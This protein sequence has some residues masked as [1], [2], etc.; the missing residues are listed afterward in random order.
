MDYIQVIEKYITNSIK[1]MFH[2]KQMIDH[3][4]IYVLV[5]KVRAKK[6]RLCL[7]LQKSYRLLG[8]L[9]FSTG[10]L[11]SQCYRP[12]IN[13]KQNPSCA[14]GSLCHY[15]M[16]SSVPIL[17]SL[18]LHLIYV[19]LKKGYNRKVTGV[20][21]PLHVFGITVKI[22]CC[23]WKT[24]S[25]IPSAIWCQLKSRYVFLFFILFYINLK[26]INSH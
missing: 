19:Y 26:M 11:S 4:C 25:F 20:S 17:S 12:K 23:F 6:R 15:F 18:S 2:V 7:T 8:F 9:Q 5:K 24:P 22:D 13:L 1:V 10:Q 21:F 16:P 3:E 14:W